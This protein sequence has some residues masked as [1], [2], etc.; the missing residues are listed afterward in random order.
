MVDL[1]EEDTAT[2]A[3]KPGEQGKTGA[4]TPPAA[5]QGK[6][7]QDNHGKS[8]ERET[9]QEQGASVAEF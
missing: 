4:A 1:V 7:S 9:G 6:T 5:L 3:A 8:E 2:S